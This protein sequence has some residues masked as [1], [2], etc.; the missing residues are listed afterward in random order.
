MYGVAYLKQSYRPIDDEIPNNPR[1]LQFADHAPVE[2]CPFNMAV[3]AVVP[4]RWPC[5]FQLVE[6]R[7]N[8]LLTDTNR[9]SIIP[10]TGVLTPSFHALFQPQE[11]HGSMSACR[12]HSVRLNLGCKIRT[13]LGWDNIRVKGPERADLSCI[14]HTSVC[15][16]SGRWS[17]SE[18]ARLRRP[19]SPTCR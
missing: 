11:S 17:L 19:R 13:R 12:R 7:Q 3:I 9:S 18:P 15:L 2:V 5:H 8:C 6:H 1:H 16:V 4:T 14:V 10:P